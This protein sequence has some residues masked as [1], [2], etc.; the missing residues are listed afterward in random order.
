MKPLG[1]CVLVFWFGLLPQEKSDTVVLNQE[2]VIFRQLLLLP[3]SEFEHD[4]MEKRFREI[5]DH[6]DPQ[7]RILYVE[8]MDSPDSCALTNKCVIDG[9]Y[10]TWQTL[11]SDYKERIPPFA[12]MLVIGGN[13]AMRVRDNQERVLQK[14]VQGQ[15]PYILHVGNEELKIVH[16]SAGRSK[17]WGKREGW[18]VHLDFFILARAPDEKTTRQALEELK[19]QT[20]IENVSVVVRRD[21]WFILD[22]DF[23][24]VSPFLPK[25][26]PPSEEAYEKAPQWTCV[27]SERGVTCWGHGEK[28]DSP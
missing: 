20:S 18:F 13:A 2:S 3:S 22:S 4:R 23:P 12:E 28:S 21:P 24:V 6:R 14:V 1:L 17:H 25:T 5:L 27:S 9:N 7:K 15:D 16:F 10:S 11:F 19:R 8:A 26:T